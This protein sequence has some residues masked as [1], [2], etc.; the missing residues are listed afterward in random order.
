MENYIEENKF[1]YSGV[2]AAKIQLAITGWATLVAPYTPAFCLELSPQDPIL[3]NVSIFLYAMAFNSSET[4][5][6]HLH[7][8]IL[9]LWPSIWVW[10]QILHSD[11]IN[12]SSLH[13]AMDVGPERR[14]NRYFPIFRIMLCFLYIKSQAGLPTAVTHMEDV[15]TMSTSMWIEESKN[16][17]FSFAASGFLAGHKNGGLCPDAVA[18][19][20]LDRIIVG[21]GSKEDAVKLL[22]H[23]M[24]ANLNQSKPSLQPLL[25]DLAFIFNQVTNGPSMLQ[26]TFF[27]SSAHT[28]V[29]ML[30]ILTLI[31][32]I[33][34]KEPK[35]RETNPDIMAVI[36]KPLLV[37]CCVLRNPRAYEN[38]A[39]LLQASFFSLIARAALVCRPIALARKFNESLAQVLKILERFAVHRPLLSAINRGLAVA[40]A[41]NRVRDGP[42]GKSLRDFQKKIDHWHKLEQ[43]YR[44]G[45]SSLVICGDPEVCLQHVS[46]ASHCYRHCLWP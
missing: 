41:I 43:K 1:N 9:P 24:K 23:R 8:Q 12:S 21:C 17:S 22:F 26:D 30:D 28:V 45:W 42:I 33:Q 19:N 7:S 38:I 2:E 18:A 39:P 44:D 11:K 31:L 35:H 15:V 46:T 32:G 36:R 34:S 13:G 20:I 29:C 27:S 37:I 40:L 10:L 6:D 5:H 25:C 14:Q 4:S 16:T 3:D